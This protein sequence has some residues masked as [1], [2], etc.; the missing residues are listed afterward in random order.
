MEMQG[1]VIVLG[2]KGRFGRAGVDAFVNRGWQV[3]ALA[4]NWDGEGPSGRAGRIRGDAFD[5]ENL[6]AACDGCDVIVNALNPPYPRWA[7]D[8]PRLTTS[9]IAAARK[10]G[11]TVMIPGNVYNYGDAMPARLTAATPQT[12]TTRKGRLRVAM[13]RAFAAA[14]DVRTIVLRAGDFMERTATGNWFDSQITK[15][16]A[17]GSVMYPGPL[18]QI[19]AWAYLPDMARAIAGLAEIRHS[20]AAF[21][22][23]GFPGYSLT[24]QELVDA[25]AL[26]SGQDLTIKG[27]PWPLLRLAGLVMPQIREVA[28]MAYL[29]QTP[30]AI[31]GAKLAAALPDFRATPLALAIA[32]AVRDKV[33]AAPFSTLTRTA[34]LP[35]DL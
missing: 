33:V 2:A 19:H 17:R 11:A 5:S 32:D 4:R 35:S 22:D 10:T 29:W 27:L 13:E 3:R 23:F 15:N 20:F 1:N 24:G 16:L 21:E 9:V 30:H 7:E 25:I 6:A 34:D 12:P 18:D 14:P 28:E 31:D 26:A 8:L